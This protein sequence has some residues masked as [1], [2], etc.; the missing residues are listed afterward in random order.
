[1][2]RSLG[3]DLPED[4]IQEIDSYTNNYRCRSISRYIRVLFGSQSMTKEYIR[5]SKL[6]QIVPVFFVRKKN[7]K[8][9]IVQYLNK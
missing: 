3:D 6:P 1:M 8:K 5:P 2:I 4:K 7:G 9:Y